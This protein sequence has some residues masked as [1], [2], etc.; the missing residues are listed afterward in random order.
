LPFDQKVGL[1]RSR[2]RIVAHDHIVCILIK[3][4]VIAP[5]L[6]E[7]FE[8][9]RFPV[10]QT[11]LRDARLRVVG[12]AQR[13]QVVAEGKWLHGN[14]PL[15][16]IRGVSPHYWRVWCQTF[17]NDQFLAVD[18]LVE[19][20]VPVLGTKSHCFVSHPTVSLDQLVP[21][22]DFY[23]FLDA[24]LDLS[25]IRPWVEPGYAPTGRP[26]IDP[27]VFFKLQLILFF[28]GLRSERQLMR[29]VADRLSL[30]WYLG[31][32]FDEPLP[33]H[34]SLT[35]IRD[36]YGR[37][38]FRRFFDRVVEL[39]Q[40]AGLVWGKELIFDA[41]QVQANADVD[42]L[43][44]RFFLHAKAEAH[45]ETLFAE[46]G[47]VA[48]PGVEEEPHPAETIPLELPR[49]LTPEDAAALANKN[50]TVWKL[51]EGC[52]LDPERPAS[53]S[54]QRITDFQVSTTDPDATPMRLKGGGARLGYH[55]HYVVDGGKDRI[56]LD[57]FVT[58][59]DVMENQPMLD[60]LRR[61]RFRYH[62]HPKRAIGDTTY[63]MVDNIVALEDDGIRAYVPL[64]H[65]D[66]RTPYYGAAWFA[67][68]ANQ[69]QYRCPQGQVLRRLKQKFTEEV[70]I[71]RAAAATCNACP[72]KAQYT[73]S[74]QGRQVRRPFAA[75]YLDRVRG[76][77]QT[78]GY[79]KAMRK[80][81]VWVEPLFGEAKD[82]H[83]LRRF[84]LRGLQKVNIEGLRIAA[85]QNLKRYL[86]A[87]GWG[88]RQGPSWSMVTVRLGGL[89]LPLSY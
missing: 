45:V 79:R 30:R 29:V 11:D 62:L 73:P 51:L 43:V 7:E 12:L 23:R 32:D 78:E 41:M 74:S 17:H 22:N 1:R 26:S 89:P 88:R 63:G 25:F 33:D 47:P 52:R 83:S 61:V 56:I 82:W 10:Q 28:E 57:A 5:R 16:S 86:A 64:A 53:G 19:N 27:V 69:D 80:R 13:G 36:R 24:R 15:A 49:E 65:F 55:D 42:S 67:Y 59:A 18:L 58:P 14:R 20:G 9:L 21:C 81:A 34:S 60:L 2:G 77:H 87:K 4:D 68:E 50:R 31:Y 46:D 75:E 6:K 8:G 38:V 85:G 39:C 3:E 84:R 71:Y 40:E 35:R 44:P 37:E 54:Y 76:Y 72:G 48:P 70:T 66:H